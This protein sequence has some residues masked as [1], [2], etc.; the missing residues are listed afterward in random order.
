MDSRIVLFDGYCNLCS[1]AVQFII[2]RDSQAKF[3]FASLQSDVAR[4]ILTRTSADIIGLESVILYEGGRIFTNSTAAIKIAQNLDGVWPLCSIF[5]LIPRQLR[6]F[7]YRWIAKNRY[8]WFGKKEQC[9]LPTMDLK[10]R[11]L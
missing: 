4:E 6:D 3:K 5:L 7:I 1:A 10:S 8:R 11:F 9:W 2:K